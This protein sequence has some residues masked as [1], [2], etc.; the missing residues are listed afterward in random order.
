M[1]VS[2][3]K[4]AVAAMDAVQPPPDREEDERELVI[5]PSRGW[6]AVNWREMLEARELLYFLA[7]R[8]VKVRYKQ[9]VLGVGWAVIPPIVTTLIF[10]VI[11]GNLAKIP[12]G[13]LPYAVFAMAG[14]LPWGY[15]SA[16]LSRSSTSLVGNRNLIS[17]VYFP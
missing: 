14:L 15:F 4:I 2:S 6:I 13:D 12:S 11:F 7:W 5:A 1:S 9:T 3:M 17:K 10:T 16:V 8:D